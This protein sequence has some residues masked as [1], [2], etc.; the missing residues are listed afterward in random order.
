MSNQPP[1]V[2]AARAVMIC[3]RDLDAARSFYEAGLGLS[4]A[5][6]TDQVDSGTRRLWG[7]GDGAMRIARLM[8][9][10]EAFGMVELVEWEGSAGE[11]IRDP[12]RPSDYGLLTLNFTTLEMERALPHLSSLGASFTSPPRAYEAGGRAI[13]E[14]VGYAPGGE[15]FTVLQVGEAK[16]NSPH[17]FA[18]AVATV[19]IVV[20]S[21]DEA[22]AFW[23]DTL[24]LSV[25][26]SDD[27]IG[28]TFTSLMRVPD[29]TR[30]RMAIMTSGGTWTGKMMVYELTPPEGSPEARNASERADGRYTGH[31][32][33]S[34]VARD[35]DAFGEARREANV[36]VLRGPVEIERPF[37]G[38]T[39]AMTIIAP[40]GTP[41]EVTER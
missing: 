30:M 2:S 32:M 17:P 27:K 40:G 9:P 24:G 39:R 19:G 7:M 34:F 13:R 5:G 33:V 22:R 37:V 41:L 35:F 26:L 29:E 20:P 3:V 4:C 1:L 31:W 6:V 25:I 21:F 14:A 11:P 38:R 8:K 23:C 12:S 28:G 15:R 16:T 10:G 36:R 18:S